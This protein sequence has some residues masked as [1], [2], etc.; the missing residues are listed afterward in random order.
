MLKNIRLQKNRQ[1]LVQNWQKKP[2][3]NP[4]KT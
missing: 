1:K 3:K 2:L 4:P